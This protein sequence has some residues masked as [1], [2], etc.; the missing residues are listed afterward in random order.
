M[1]KNWL[2]KR[3][4]I[5]VGMVT[6]LLFVWLSYNI[7][8]LRVVAAELIAELEMQMMENPGLTFYTQPSE[9]YGE[10]MF[11]LQMLRVLILV[12][13]AILLWHF[14]IYKVLP[15]RIKRHTPQKETISL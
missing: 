2:T 4:F 7:A 14:I 3:V 9:I 11:L 5:V 1:K 6:V 13:M 10:P 12:P 15:P 8:N